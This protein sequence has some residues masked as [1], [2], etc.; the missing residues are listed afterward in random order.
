MDTV[1]SSISIVDLLRTDD[2]S[3]DDWSTILRSSIYRVFQG[4]NEENDDGAQGDRRTQQLALSLYC[5][6]RLLQLIPI[7][8]SYSQ[9]HQTQHDFV[10][11]DFLNP[12]GP[13]KGK[14]FH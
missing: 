13:S 4:D 2:L 10:Q 8:S 14:S 5:D 1:G 6:G 12:S 3:I 11:S 9:H 7:S